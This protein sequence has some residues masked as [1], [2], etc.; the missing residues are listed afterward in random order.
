MIKVKDAKHK[1]SLFLTEQLNKLSNNAPIIAFTKPV[2]M[3]VLNS[4]VDKLDGI[5]AALADENGNID[6]V[7]ILNDMAQSLVS[8]KPFKLNTD[9]VGDIEIG[10]GHVKINI[11]FTDKTLVL[12]VDDINN[13]QQMLM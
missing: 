6:G 5:M 8:T 3:R 12:N 11:P 7:G 2:I 9:I 10:N 13:L 1:I 4:Y